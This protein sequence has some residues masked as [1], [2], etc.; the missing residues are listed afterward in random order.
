MLDEIK[1]NLRN[2]CFVSSAMQYSRLFSAKK[3]HVLLSTY[4]GSSIHNILCTT[5]GCNSLQWIYL[6]SSHTHAKQ[7]NTSMCPITFCFLF[8]IVYLLRQHLHCMSE[9]Q[10]AVGMSDRAYQS[11]ARADKKVCSQLLVC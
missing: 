7:C 5:V 2:F 11:D 10:M 8:W 3:I 4:A 6:H 9:F 1:E